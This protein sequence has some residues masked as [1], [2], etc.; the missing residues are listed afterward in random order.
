MHKSLRDI[1]VR[2]VNKQVMREE[3]F[4]PNEYK[5][6]FVKVSKDRPER[7]AEEIDDLKHGIP[8]IED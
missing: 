6:H 8:K 5:A 2:D 1:G 7:T 4:T 3:F